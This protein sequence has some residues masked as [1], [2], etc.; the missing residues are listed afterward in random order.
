MPSSLRGTKPAYRRQ[1]IYLDDAFVKQ[2]QYL[3]GKFSPSVRFTPPDEISGSVL[4]SIRF[5][6]QK[7]EAILNHKPY[8]YSS[9]Y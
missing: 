2:Y 5:I 4:A 6:L 9:N 8:I 7:F 3:L 1:A